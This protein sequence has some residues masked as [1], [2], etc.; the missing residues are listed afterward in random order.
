MTGR[1][2]KIAMIGVG[3]MAAQHAACLRHVPGVEVVSCASRSAEKAAAFAQ[4][5]GIAEPRLFDDVMRAPQADAIWVVLPCDLMAPMAI[6]LAHHGLPMFLEKPVG[7]SPVETRQVAERVDVPN[8]VGLN[9]RFYE[10]IVRGREMITAAGGARAIEVHMPE[11]LTRVPAGAHKDMTLANWQYANSVHLLDLFRYFGGE[12]SHVTA[13]NR[14]ASNADR[15]YNALLSFETG[16]RGLYN[17]QWYAPGG[18]RVSVYADDLSIT[19]QP[20]EQANVMRRGSAPEI[21]RPSGPDAEFKAGLFGQ[22]AAFRDLVQSGKLSENAA[23]LADYL[24]SVE[25]VDKLTVDGLTA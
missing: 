6:Q 23:D 9:R 25:L 24:K 21:I 11:D 8:M 15:S 14:I 2:C 16:A 5:H 3:P 10:V 20:I 1:T 18:W 19:F 7:L 22:A 17:A 12:V 4:Q 13:E